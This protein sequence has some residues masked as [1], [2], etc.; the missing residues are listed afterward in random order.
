M[1]AL[2]LDNETGITEAIEHAKT[3]RDEA[4]VIYANEESTAEDVE[5]ADRM[6]DEAGQMVDRVKKLQEL[7]DIGK[8]ID[9]P[10]EEAKNEDFADSQEFFHAVKLAGKGT[11]DNRLMQLHEE[12]GL[13]STKDLSGNIGGSGGFALTGERLAGIQAAMAEQSIVMPRATVIPMNGRTVDIVRVKQTGTTASQFHQFGGMVAYWEGEADTITNS[14][15]NFS[16]TQ[17]TARILAAL[18]YIPNTVLADSADAIDALIMGDRGFGGLLGNTADYAFLQGSGSNQPLGILN[19]GAK[20]TQTR[21]A[22]NNIGYDDLVNL[23]NKTIP[24]NGYVWLANIGTRAELVGMNGPSGNASYLWGDA[25]NGMPDRLLGYPI[26]FTEKVPALGSTGDIGLYDFSHY[27]IGDRQTITV[28]TD[29]S[30]KFPQHVTGFKAMARLDGTPV[31][32][33]YLTLFDGSTTVTPFALL[34]A[35]QT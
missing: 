15:M 24:G 6:V 19:S 25:T 1:F 20:L 21:V 22:S 13:I 31:L 11:V 29:S 4:L 32:E 23:M 7:K 16:T 28:D 12:R 8:V 14:D 27:Y 30:F 5:K 2:N 17:L 3:L 33:T 26:V 35:T 9:F 18:T 34:D 10:S